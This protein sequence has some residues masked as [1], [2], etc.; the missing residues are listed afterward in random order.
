[1]IEE[2]ISEMEHLEKP[3]KKLRSRSYY[4]HHRG[5]SIVRKYNFLKTIYPDGAEYLKEC[6]A[7][8]MLSKGKIHCSCPC[9]K[10]EKANNIPTIQELI[11]RQDYKEQLKEIS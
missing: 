9:C 4:R 8:G 7:P 11:N 5:R 6:K 2:F 3:K 10:Y 1:M